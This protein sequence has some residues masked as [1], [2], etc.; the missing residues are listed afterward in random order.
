MREHEVNK[1]DNFICGWYLEDTNIC[2][3]LVE[4]HKV[5]P[6]KGIGKSLGVVNKEYKD[7]I[8]CR[9]Q[10]NMELAEQYASVHLQ[11][12][13]LEYVK[14]YKWCNDYSPFAIT[15]SINVQYYK[16]TAGYHA[17]HT[18]RA[19]PN[20]PSV[21]R[22]LVFM[23]YLNDVYDGGETEFYHQ[24]IKVKP[25]KGLTLIWPADW[26]FTHRGITSPTEEK[27]VVTGWYNFIVR[28]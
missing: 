28:D 7:S 25:E 9:L 12:C 17:W 4:W 23:T 22:H 13:L 3:K 8:D 10:D 26:T 2:D 11:K 24:Q 19:W 18:E 15:D 16:P 5:T 6:D 27:Y 14:K 21:T 1:L 20:Y